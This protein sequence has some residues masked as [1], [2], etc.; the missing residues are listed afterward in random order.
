MFARQLDQ[1]AVGICPSHKLRT[2]FFRETS[3]TMT[4]FRIDR[5]LT[6]GLFHPV[7]QQNR[8]KAAI[9]M[10]HRICDESQSRLPYYRTNTS[11]GVFAAQMRF[12][13]ENGYNVIDLKTLIESMNSGN[14]PPTGSVVLTFD[15]GFRDFYTEAFPVLQQHGFPA[16]IFLMT[17][18][19]D[20]SSSFDGHKCL[21][22]SQVRELGRYNVSFGSH[23][24]SHPVLNSL[25]EK[26]LDFELTRSK[27][28]I[29]SELGKEVEAFS[30][31][32]AFPEHDRPFVKRLK[33]KLAQTGYKYGVTTRIGTVSQ[34]DTGDPFSLKRLPV[35]SLDDNLL[36]KA[37]LEGAYNWMYICQ[38]LHKHLSIPRL[39]LH[40]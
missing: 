24:V 21:S 23:T 35:N 16:S 20:E 22:W 17:K 8:G 7:S 37:K 40:K 5:F 10:Y 28:R 4:A 32:F 39:L 1:L 25:T 26:E 27:D 30:Y 38:M 9:L 3:I 13:H 18:F 6:L 33:S 29:Q 19:I 36:L 12:L 2:H 34:R 15:D 31:P 14:A 11:P